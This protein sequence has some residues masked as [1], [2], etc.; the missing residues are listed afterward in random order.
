MTTYWIGA[1]GRVIRAT[2]DPEAAPPGA[3]DSTE[4]SPDSARYQRFIAGAWVD[5][6]DRADQEADREIAAG[7]EGSRLTRLIFDIEFDQE[8]R[9]RVLEG[10]PAVT[11]AG[12]RNGLLMRLQGV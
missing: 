1:T 11:R 2:S 5:D 12:Y 9:I 10:R 4:I 3:V 6:V 8:N 7:F